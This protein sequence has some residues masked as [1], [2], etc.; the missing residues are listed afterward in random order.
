MILIIIITELSLK[1]TSNRKNCGSVQED[2][3]IKVLI[4]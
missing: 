2:A 3:K 4:L 1:K